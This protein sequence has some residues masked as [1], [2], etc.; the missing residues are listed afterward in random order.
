MFTKSQIKQ[1]VQEDM[2]QGDVTVDAIFGTGAHSG[3]MN[4]IPTKAV[5]FAKQELIV[6][7]MTVV[8]QVLK[9]EFPRIKL[10]V[11]MK[12]GQNAKIKDVLAELRG[13]IRDLLKA[14]RLC[15]NLLQQL[16]G[17]ATR[18]AEFVKAVGSAKV[19]VLDTRKTT[20][21]L[22]LA[23]KKAVR[24]GGGCN[25]RVSL[26]DQYLIKENH[27]AQAGSVTKALEAVFAHRKQQKRR[28]RV[29]IEVTNFAEFKEALVLQP[30]IILLDNM[31]VKEIETI[32]AYRRRQ[33]AQ[34]RRV[35]LEISGGVN[36]KTI[37][38][39]ARTGVERISVGALTHSAPAVDISMLI[40]I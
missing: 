17:V 30:D 25:H 28:L 26:S 27:I 3:S 9:Q 14:E 36:L 13:D 31:S 18:T 20:P 10:N 12:D 8:Q 6:S 4:R 34:L 16:S 38:R 11:L 22:R 33:R 2:P 21:G 19:Q 23:E 15:V 1:F 5:I 39:L 29:E 24:D 37:G 32:V 7:G 35:Q 40:K